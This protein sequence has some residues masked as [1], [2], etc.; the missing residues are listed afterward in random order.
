MLV[1]T[2]SEAGTIRELN[3]DALLV[4]KA[5]R[6]VAIADGTGPEGVAAAPALLEIFAGHL[7]ENAHVFSTEEAPE[8]L[9]ASLAF[10][11]AR[12][13]ATMPDS[14]A[15]FAAI[16]I[17]REQAALAWHGSCRA[18]TR[19]TPHGIPAQSDRG[20][21]TATLPTRMAARFFLVSEGL[22]GTFS[23]NYRKNLLDD[24]LADFSPDK[25]DFFWSEAN[26]IYDG[27]D[28]SLIFLELD[29]TD[30][31]AGNP[32]EI[33]LFTD[34]DRQ[35]SI[36]LWAPASLAAAMALF[37]AFMARKLYLVYQSIS[38]QLR[39]P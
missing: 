6:L 38:Q 36:P 37:A 24:L 23:D 8:R 39:W 19:P 33:E 3:Q 26:R 9:A 32:K 31:T 7:C 34:F 16:W 25:L 15:G 21:K 1:F 30:L 29:K 20:I 2:R 22:A 4:N 11:R 17:H 35:F 12:I 14:I 27:D 13:S 18:G 28:R 10:A 5:A